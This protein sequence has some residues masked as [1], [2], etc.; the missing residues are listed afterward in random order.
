VKLLLDTHVWI[1][2]QEEP[3]RLGPHAKRLLLD[4]EHENH[5]CT[6]S[7]LELARLVATGAVVLSIAL[8]EWV[9][10]ALRTLHARTV[11]VSHEVAMDAY[12]LPG[13][14]HKDSAD[15]ILISAARCH[16]L[17]LLTADERILTYRG[18]HSRDARR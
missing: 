2:A 7:T 9:E 16:E 5:V 14:F 13:A 17:T 1:W 3:D 6:I 11:L 10:R 18:V 12:V 4:A 15:R 8:R